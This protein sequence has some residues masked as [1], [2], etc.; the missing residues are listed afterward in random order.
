M[1]PMTRSFSPGGVPTSAVADYYARRA[2]G[3]VG[4]II[5]EGTVVNR[6]ASSN[7]PNIPRFHGKAELGG[8]QEVIT[9]VHAVGGVMAPQ[10]WHMGVVAPKDSGWL[11]T[12]PFEGPSGLVA[13]GK[14]G[15]VAM[16]EKDI[17]ATI[18]P[19]PIFMARSHLV[20]GR[21]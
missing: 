3:E 21:R 9:R 4:F 19:F 18:R 17:A 1:A 20:G 15:G 8:W 2:V 6:P 16:T 12:A 11:T 14:I 5:S 10:L 7:D 13:P